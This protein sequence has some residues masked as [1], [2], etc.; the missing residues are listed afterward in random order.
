MARCIAFDKPTA[1]A[2]S[3]NLHLLTVCNPEADPVQTALQS[4]AP[5]SLL[6]VPS[7]NGKHVLVAKFRRPAL[8]VAD[9]EPVGFE[10]SGFL[11]LSDEPV[12]V[13][14][15]PVRKWWQKLLE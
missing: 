3:R 1:Q 11:G 15:S 2:I 5:I 14:G 6:A 10:A 12:F 7:E 13:P 8:A 4:N 9:N